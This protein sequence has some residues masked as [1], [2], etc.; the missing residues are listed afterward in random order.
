MSTRNFTTHGTFIVTALSTFSFILL[1]SKCHYEGNERSSELK[2]LL[3]EF[4]IGKWSDF[5]IAT[6]PMYVRA[7]WITN[8]KSKVSL[9]F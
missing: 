2:R 1:A 5:C 7:C 6:K 4:I 8:I 3:S 9:L